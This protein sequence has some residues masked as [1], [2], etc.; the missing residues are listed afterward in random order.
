MPVMPPAPE[1]ET[2]EEAEQR[3]AEHEQRRKEYEAEQERRAEERRQEMER[4]EQEYEAEQA[5]REEL[6]QAREATYNR[7]LEN[8]PA[9]FNAAQLRVLLRA[10]VNLD[11]YTFADDLA[12]EISA[13]KSMSP[14][15]AAPKRYCC[16]PSTAPEMTS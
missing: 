5:R 8:A 10:I 15:T 9:S 14:T 3:R 12:E 13:E 4:Q 7:I 1:E 6:R 2:E 11:P 16:R